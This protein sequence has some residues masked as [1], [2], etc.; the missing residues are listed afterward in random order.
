M[1]VLANL[2]QAVAVILDRVLQ[3]YYYVV[4]VAVLISWVGPD[5]FNPVVRMLRAI[6]EPVFEWV[7]RHVPFTMVGMMDLSPILVFFGIWF[8]RI[9]LIRSLLDLAL[10]LR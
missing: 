5:P 9:F 10:R 1:F 7:R 4:L 6:T 2:I 8:L 3:I